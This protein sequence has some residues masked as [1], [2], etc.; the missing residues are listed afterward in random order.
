MQEAKALRY[1]ILSSFKLA[2]QEWISAEFVIII[3]VIK[4]TIATLLAMS[5]SMFF[6][7]S[8]PQ[9]SIFTVFIVMQIHSGLVFSKSFYRFLG[10]LIGFIIALILTSSFSQD[11]YWFM[12]FFTLWI[13]ICAAAGFKY[14]NFISYG[15][16][17]SGYT[18]ALIVLPNIDNP[19]NIYGFAIERISEVVVGLLCASVVSEIIFPKQLSDTLLESEKQKYKNIYFSVLDMEN[20]FSK[21]KSINNFSK[22]ILGSDSLLVNAV[23][24]SNVKKKDKI[25]Y[26][27]LNSEFMHLSITFHSL[28]NII[29]SILNQQNIDSKMVLA[30]EDMYKPIKDFLQKNSDE[31]FLGKKSENII[32]EFNY[33]KSEIK[34][35]YEKNKKQFND[36]EFDILN[37]FNSSSYLI[38][39][40]F[41]EFYQYTK[42]YIS[43]IDNKNSNMDDT[44]FTESYKF[45]TYT[46]TPLVILSSFRAVVVLLATTSFWFLTAW[47]YAPFVIISAVATTLLFSSHPN[48][49]NASKSFLKGAFISFFVAGIYNFY[50]IPT[51]VSDIPSFCFVMAPIFAFTA[52]LGSS[53][54]RGLFSFGFIFIIITVCSMNLHYSMNYITFFESSISSLIGIII[55]GAAYELINSWSDSWTKRRVSNLLCEKIMTLTN[56]KDKTRRV[57]LES[58]GLDLVQHFSTQGRLTTQSNNLIFQW[59]LSNLEIGRAIIDIKNELI[60]VKKYNQSKKVYDILDLIKEYFRQKDEK[61]KEMIFQNFKEAFIGFKE[62][63]VPE[64]VIEQKVTKN[65][66]VELTLIYTLILNKISLPTKGEIN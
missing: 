27:R 3:Y 2:I 36:L 23:F 11:R 57:I 44:A 29:N 31:L 15:F 60:E 46:D 18:V 35:Q 55:S 54:Q 24:E 65:I 32:E 51:Y 26:K 48:P 42:T 6:N 53:A 58:Q 38:L 28:K 64:L 47:H 50:L 21:E 52:W 56:K 9:T 7:L 43:F 49:V 39:R 4:L 62:S 59:L 66:I 45:S 13:A 17:L 63:V 61:N 22:N 12:G 41:D 37:D 33:V 20:I 8:S 40:F 30:L 25:Y 14:R 10:T 16:V 5:I 34:L 19:L 1:S